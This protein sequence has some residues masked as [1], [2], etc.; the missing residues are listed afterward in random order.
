[1]AAAKTEQEKLLAEQKFQ[2]ELKL[3]EENSRHQIALA[4]QKAKEEANKAARK[5]RNEII[6]GTL[7]LL[8]LI[9]LFLFLLNRQHNL[10]R[11]AI[12]KA[13]TQHKMA[14]LELQSLRAQLNPHFMFNS[15]NAIQELILM[16]ENDK[17]HTY[18]ARFAKLLRMLLE[19]A[20]SPFIPLARELEFLELY[21]S[22]ENLRIPD[23]KYS[24]TIDKGLD[25]EQVKIPNM[26]LQ[27]FIE[28]AIWHGL[29]HKPA[30]DRKLNIRVLQLADGVQ[31]EIEDNGV[32]RKKA[33]ELKSIYRKA[34][35][36]KGMELLT[37]RFKLLN[38]EY[39]FE[40]RTNTTDVMNK[41]EVAGTLVT[42]NVPWELARENKKAG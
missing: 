16:E 31:Y 35:R 3:A 18:L 2:S 39:R 9:S 40:I 37:K 41:E 14:E 24:I 42:I 1:M 19:N 15:L 4:D 13:E 21:L 11:K 10:R 26:I 22:L 23:L 5:R 27:P 36:S 25:T 17:S 30:G 12:E 33:A 34:H 6:F 29:S 32:G 28:N 8:G 20:N 38:E 7:A